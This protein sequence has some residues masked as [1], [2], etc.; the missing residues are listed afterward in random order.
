MRSSMKMDIALLLLLVKSAEMRWRSIYQ[1]RAML[2]PKVKLMTKFL[3]AILGKNIIGITLCPFGIYVKLEYLTRVKTINHEK[4]H[5]QQQLEMM[6]A[7]AIMSVI[8][9]VVL[10]LLGIFAWWMLLLL[11]FPL[12]F[13][14]LWYIIEWFLRIFINGNKA[15]ISLSFEREAYTNAENQDYLKTRKPYS[16]LKYMVKKK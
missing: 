3:K 16:W 11:V 1:K 9:G 2:K 7:G 14:Y 8:T 5:W 12:L 6:V 13:F 4:I 10:M 15:Y